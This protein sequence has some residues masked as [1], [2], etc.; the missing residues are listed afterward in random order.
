MKDMPSKIADAMYRQCQSRG[1]AAP[2]D[3]LMDIGVLD[4]AKY[5]STQLHGRLYQS[6]MRHSFPV[7]PPASPPLY[8]PRSSD[9]QLEI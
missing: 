1:Y 6:G 2:V 4:K 3:V 8:C 9:P 7:W 5:R